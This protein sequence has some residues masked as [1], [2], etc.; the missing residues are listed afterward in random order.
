L[1]GFSYALSAA[2]LTTIGQGSNKTI[3]AQQTDGA[4]NT[5][6]SEPFSFVVDTGAP[7]VSIT[8]IGGPD[9]TIS[10]QSGDNTVVGTAEASL[11]VSI[12]F[13]S[14]LLGTTTA[15][16]SGGFSYALS[17]ENL[18][19][20]GQGSDKTITAQQ[21]DGAGNTG[22]SEP[23]SFVVDTGAP[24]VSITTI[25]GPDSTISSQ[26]GDNTVVGTAEA[27]R[28]VSIFFGST[29]LGTTTANGS[30]GFSY[31]LSAANLSTIG[32]GSNKTITAQ[33][34]DGAGN[35]GSS[36]PFCLQWIR[37]HRW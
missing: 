21:T 32:Q 24:V 37:G 19:T 1:G 17:A 6:S 28:E 12:F 25:G 27:S 29:L 34:T 4:G 16:G 15:N 31:A 18:S 5:G 35:T 36:E 23:F 7:V 13:D 30:G 14:T 11:E 26:S 8:T 3:T 33:Q 20:I 9:S 10:S 2:N 22:S